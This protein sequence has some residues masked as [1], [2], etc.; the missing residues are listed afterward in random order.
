MHLAVRD[1]IILHETGKCGDGNTKADR[2]GR[3]IDRNAVFSPARIALRAAHRTKSLQLFKALIAEQI[4]D[5]M[6]HRPRMRLYRYLILRAQR[7][8]IKRR[9]D[10]RHRGAACLM[11]ADLQP[12][13][14][15][16]DMIGVVDD[17]RGKP[18]QP[19]V[20]RFQHADKFRAI[21]SSSDFGG[22]I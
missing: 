20:D 12:I 3:K 18:A 17:P 4:V 5:S 13:T 14:A 11:P 22:D 9:H 8:E 7:M 6:Q 10:R 21:G 1:Q 16:A 19:G 15:F 2:A